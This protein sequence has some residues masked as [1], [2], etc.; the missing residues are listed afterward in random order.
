MHGRHS[1][2]RVRQLTDE[3]LAG[4]TSVS[5]IT[6]LVAVLIEGSHWVVF[7]NRRLRALKDA[8]EMRP[9]DAR[10]LRVPCIIHDAGAG[11]VPLPVVA[12][13]LLS[14]T[15]DNNGESAP[16]YE[17]IRKRE[18]AEQARNCRGRQRE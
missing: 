15:T 9:R 16:F 1:G 7:G 13:L 17:R 12:K 8:H 18:A 5:R 11:P 3:I 4:R 6:P 14:M 2:K 10:T